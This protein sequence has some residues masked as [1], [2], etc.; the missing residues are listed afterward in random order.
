MCI[1]LH[2]PQGISVKPP[3]WARKIFLNAGHFL[4]RSWRWQQITLIILPLLGKALTGRCG[5]SPCSIPLGSSSIYYFFSLF[6]I[7]EQSAYSYFWQLYKGR[8][9]TGLQVAVR[10][11][12]SKGYSIRNLR[13][14]L[15]LLSKLRHPNLVCLLGHCIDAS[16]QDDL[17]FDRVFLV[18]EYVSYGDFQAC[19]SGNY[20]WN[21]YTA[22]F[23]SIILSEH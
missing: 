4:C 3:R 8:L 6:N 20:T 11:L 13:L 10:C 23:V 5:F 12:P 15:D 17:R 19:I 14:R 9:Q 2:T 7:M 1:L 16:V 18:Y 21:L 22:Q